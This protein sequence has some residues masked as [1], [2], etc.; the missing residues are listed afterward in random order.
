MGGVNWNQ[1]S[2]AR[3][4][5][6]RR[7]HRGRQPW[8]SFSIVGVT[9][10][11]VSRDAS[12]RRR[13]KRRR[14]RATSTSRRR[15]RTTSKTRKPLLDSSP[16]KSSR[17]KSEETMLEKQVWRHGVNLRHKWEIRL[18]LTTFKR[19]QFSSFSNFNSITVLTLLAS[20]NEWSTCF[21]LTCKAAAW[22]DLASKKSPKYDRLL[23]QDSF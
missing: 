4:L 12:C 1:V 8:L 2:E 23:D 18:A 22:P 16:L 21:D 7:S 9:T 15:R 6:H 11:V 5:L 3:H 17:F 13:R 14:R 19:P 20:A 10:F